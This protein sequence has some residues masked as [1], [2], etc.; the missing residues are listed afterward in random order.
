M[1]LNLIMKSNA[2]IVVASV[3]NLDENN[4]SNMGLSYIAVGDK[5]E[6]HIYKNIFN[7][8]HK[9]IIDNITIATYFYLIKKLKKNDFHFEKT[10][11]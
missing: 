6:I 3:G 9:E 5:K 2:D 8:S 7:G 4:G 10:I 1:A 11:V